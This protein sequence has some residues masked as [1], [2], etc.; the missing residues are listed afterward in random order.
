[1]DTLSNVVRQCF[2]PPSQD[3][4]SNMVALDFNGV[5]KLPGIINGLTMLWLRWGK[6]TKV[7]Y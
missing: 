1:M 4:R 5:S 6:G 2:A 3:D 7:F